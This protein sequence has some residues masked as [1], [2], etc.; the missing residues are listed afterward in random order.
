[1]PGFDVEAIKKHSL[2]VRE[3]YT[4]QPFMDKI[5][6]LNIGKPGTGKTRLAKYAPKPVLIHS[7]DRGGSKTA[8]IQPLI[9]SGDIIVDTRF[10]Q[11]DWHNPRAFRLWEKTFSNLKKIGFFDAIGTYF[12]DSATTFAD[13]MMYALLKS[14]GDKRGSRAGELPG[15]SDYHLQQ[16]TMVDYFNVMMSLPC[17]VVVNG[18]VTFIK[19]EVTGAIMTGILLAGKASDKVPLTFDE[20]YISKMF[21][22]KFVLQTKTDNYYSAETRVGGLTFKTYEE[23]NLYKLLEKAGLPFKDKPP[24]KSLIKKEIQS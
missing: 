9:E 2:E 12:L 14:G 10:E 15:L 19:D 21:A 22:G 16:Y 6:I 18:H 7:F 1:M 4:E 17:H 20:K 11:D 23:Q 3:Y 13:A 24:I 8:E 5:N